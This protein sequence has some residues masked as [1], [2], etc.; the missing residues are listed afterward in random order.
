M[1]S[2]AVRTGTAPQVRPGVVLVGI[3]L[4]SLNLRAGLAV[5]PAVLQQARAGLGISAGGAGL[6][7]S[8]SLVAMGLGSFLAVRL[9]AHVGRARAMSVAVGMLLVGSLIRLAPTLGTLVLGSVALG[10][11]IGVAGVALSGLVKE[12]LEQR[13]GLATGLYVVSMLIGATIASASGVPLSRALG[14]WSLAL[15]A[16]S[17]PAA[18]ALAAW[19]PVARR[20]LSDARPAPEL[21]WRA[22]LARVFAVY[23]VLSS[24][25]FYGWLTW[26]APYYADRGLGAQSAALLLSVF[27]LGQIPAAL[28]FPALAERHHRW[29]AWSWAAIGISLVG[30]LGVLLVPTAPLGPLPWVVAVSVGVGAGFPMALTLMAWKSRS[31]EEASGATAVGLGVG[32]L[33]AA[34]APLL[35]GVLRDATDSFTTPLL[36]L[37]VAACLQAGVAWVYQRVQV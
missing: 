22:P 9:D 37:L 3:L 11:G 21:P 6:V 27:S 36:V 35:M 30:T 17:I 2:P 5:Y 16:W 31:P 20:A 4:I 19:L 25:Q 13:A 23:M 34:L 32:Y 14:G 18:L 10:V 8:G 7:Q 15:G 26:M 12:H 24:A 29:L 28:A 33:G 1:S